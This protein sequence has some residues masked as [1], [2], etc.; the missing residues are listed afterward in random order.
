MHKL[1]S[2]LVV[3]ALCMCAGPAFA[4]TALEWV[5]LGNVAGREE[6]YKEAIKDYTQAIGM[7]PNIPNAYYNRGYVYMKMRK[8]KLAGKDLDHATALRPN[9]S[10]AHH[11]RGI[12][13]FYRKKYT[14]AIAEYND[15]LEVEPNNIRYH[16]SRM[17]AYFKLGN[18]DGAWR[19]VIQIQKLGGTVNPTIVNMLKAK[20]YRGQSDGR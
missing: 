5:H 3:F 19:E 7:D 4:E 11:L 16:I 2:L 15:A 6:K 14:Q 8:Y 17:S 20:Y 10:A 1:K 12:L 13:Y 18:G 9:Y